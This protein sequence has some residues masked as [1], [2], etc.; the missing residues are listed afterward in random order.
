MGRVTIEGLVA[1]IEG[2]LGI[3]ESLGSKRQRMFEPNNR[4]RTTSEKFISFHL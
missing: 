3:E 4:I 2:Q 1:F